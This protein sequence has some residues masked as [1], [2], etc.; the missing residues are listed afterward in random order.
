MPWPMPWRHSQPWAHRWCRATASSCWP[1]VPFGKVARLSAIRLFRTVVYARICASVAVA[2]DDRAGRVGGA[3]EVLPAAVDQQQRVASEPLGGVR[4][5]GVM[6]HRR[7][8]AEA[9]DRAERRP[10]VLGQFAAQRLEPL[11]DRDLGVRRAVR[12]SR[13]SAAGAS[14][15]GRPSGARRRRRRARPRSSA[16]S[17]ARRGSGPGPG[18]CA[19]P[20]RG[21]P[22]SS[23]PDRSSSAVSAGSARRLGD[24]RVRAGSPPRFGRASRQLRCHAR[25]VDEEQDRPSGGRGRTPARPGSS[26]RRRRAGSA[27]TRPRRAR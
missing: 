2:Q 21:G 18:A 7:V 15:P 20:R 14:A 3:V 13:A 17:C 4:I 8:R 10:A 16:P 23:S 19:A 12:W 22:C 5:R 25:F 1:V 24:G 27:A 6:A 26:A 11:R 9:D